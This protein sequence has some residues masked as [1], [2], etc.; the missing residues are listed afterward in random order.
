MTVILPMRPD[1]GKGFEPA[2]PSR[3]TPWELEIIPLLCLLLQAQ[4]ARIRRLEQLDRQ[5]AVAL[6][7]QRR[8]AGR[9][10]A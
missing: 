3:R 8:S 9:R 7:E 2:Q 6:D 10:A 1:S 4:E 5:K